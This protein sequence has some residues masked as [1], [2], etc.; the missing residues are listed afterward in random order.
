MRSISYNN[1]NGESKL[2]NND[3]SPASYSFQVFIFTLNVGNTVNLDDSFSTLVNVDVILG[4]DWAKTKL[5]I[6]C[7][8]VQNTKTLLR[9]TR[10]TNAKF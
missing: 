10:S 8:I 9:V 6:R 4:D 2:R 7:K 1:Q 5:S 3:V